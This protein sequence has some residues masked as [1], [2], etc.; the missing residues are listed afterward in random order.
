MKKRL[1]IFQLILAFF[2]TA[3]IVSQP[4]NGS[5]SPFSL[6]FVPFLEYSTGFLGE[7]LFY[8]PPMQNSE[9]SRLKWEKNALLYGI[10]AEAKYK[11]LN[12]DA[13]FSM[14][15]HDMAT[16]KMTDKD[17]ENYANTSIITKY[18]S[19]KNEI[20]KI[21]DIKVGFSYDFSPVKSIV[22]SPVVEAGY[23]YDSFKRPEAEAWYNFYGMS[24]DDPS[25]IHYPYVRWDYIKRRYVYGHVLGIDFVRES[26]YTWA[27]INAVLN[28]DRA[29]KFKLGA[30]I[31]PFARFYSTD[32]HWARDTD[33]Q[34]NYRKNYIE[35][36]IARFKHLK[37]NLDVILDITKNLSFDIG[38][39]SLMSLEMNRGIVRTN[40]Y[41]DTYL[42]SYYKKLSQEVAESI[43]EMNVKAGLK[44]KVL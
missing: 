20:D 4:E 13:S 31:S 12:L 3:N 33:L 25:S 10:S 11:R 17:W 28:A 37:L 27:G 2:C 18:S 29:I 44:I 21:Q 5:S 34:I 14:L 9:I 19:G 16:G 22:I 39:S 24:W 7:T 8:P 42:G 15:L 26:F 30:K 35:E 36:Q 40:V 6:N 1:L 43:Q 32:T 23:K 41:S 38:I